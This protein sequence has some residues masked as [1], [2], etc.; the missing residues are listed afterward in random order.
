MGGAFTIGGRVAR[1]RVAR[2]LAA[3]GGAMLV[4]GCAHALKEPPPLTDVLGDARGHGPADVDDLV[5]KGDALFADRTLAGAHGAL[6]SYSAAAAADP[7]R[8]D[9]LVRAI[10]TWVWLTDHETDP[11]ARADAAARAVQAAQW[12]ARRSPGDAACDY[13]L[14][15]ALGVQARERPSTGLSALPEIESAFK[16]ARDRAPRLEGA[17]PD[18]A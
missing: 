2:G 17:G 4:A 5:A 3:L 1:G 16:R 11:A 7:S 8:G 9:A 18:R 10:G 14:G 6:E 15:A 12:C 13:W